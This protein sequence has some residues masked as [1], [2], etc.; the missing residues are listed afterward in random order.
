MYFESP[1][2]AVVGRTARNAAL[3]APELVAQHVKRDM[4]QGV[5]YTFHGKPHTPE[6]V[7]AV[8]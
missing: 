3:I 8:I 5:E 1:R 7:S 4:G 2:H 6:M